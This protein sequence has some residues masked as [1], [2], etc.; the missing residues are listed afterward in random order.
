MT[1]LICIVVGFIT[2]LLLGSLYGLIN[3]EI[4]GWLSIMPHGIL[5]LA[6][7]FLDPSQRATIYQDEWLPELSYIL[8]CADDRPITRL[9][10]GIKFAAGLLISSHR[11]ARRLTGTSSRDGMAARTANGT[12]SIVGSE[13]VTT[14]Q[15]RAIYVSFTEA[16]EDHISYSNLIRLLGGDRVIRSDGEKPPYYVFKAPHHGRAPNL[17]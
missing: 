4:R 6:A 8:R 17:D 7:T 16:D 13:E 9:I 15:G 12:V 2:A 5:R 3:E 11:V 10:R 1:G 14:G